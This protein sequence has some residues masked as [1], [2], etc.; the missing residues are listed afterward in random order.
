M[1]L[2]QRASTWAGLAVPVVPSCW[3]VI[4]ATRFPV[5]A[6]SCRSMPANSAQTMPAVVLSP[7]P[8][9]STGPATG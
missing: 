9:M 1:H 4:D 8:T 6:A 3:T 5:A 2:A 7:A